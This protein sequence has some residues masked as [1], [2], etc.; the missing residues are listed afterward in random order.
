MK[1]S[2]WKQRHPPTGA[3]RIV[4]GEPQMIEFC[5]VSLVLAGAQGMRNGM[6]SRT[7]I[8]DLIF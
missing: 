4:V 5:W 3:K 1:S 8:P 6:T 7:T 2:E